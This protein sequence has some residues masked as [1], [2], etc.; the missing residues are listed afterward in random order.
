MNNGILF[1][2]SRNA[3]LQRC[4]RE[5]FLHTNYAYGEYETGAADRERNHVHLLKQLKNKSLFKSAI[6][7]QSMR[8]IFVDGMMVS[9]LKSSVLHDFYL[10]KDCML[11]GEYENDHLQHPLLQSFYYEEENFADMFTDLQNDLTFWCTRLFENDLFMHLFSE[12]MHNFYPVTEDVPSVYAG[13]LEIHFPMCGIIKS[14]NDYYCL[15]FSN[16]AEFYSGQAFLHLLHCQHKLHISP[17]RVRHVFINENEPLRLLNNDFEVDI[18]KEIEHLAE[19]A[20]AY[21]NLHNELQ[22]VT[23]PFS[24]P[25]CGDKDLCSICRFR[26]FCRG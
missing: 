21:F 20:G 11:L 2:F 4:M 18:S 9:D 16:N 7:Q 1:S 3:M 22:N 10:A 23:D 24:I 12:E 17:E 19:L 6:M 15:N 13:D 25:A 8:K 5:Y 14:N 26:E